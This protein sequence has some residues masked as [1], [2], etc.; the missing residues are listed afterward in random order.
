MTKWFAFIFVLG[1]CS[2][3][4]SQSVIWSDDFSSPSN[5]NMTNSSQ[6]ISTDWTITSNQLDIPDCAPTLLPFESASSANGFALINSYGQA[7][8]QDGDGGIVAQITNATPIDLSSYPNV[9]LKFQ[10]SYRWW[11]GT[12]GVRVS[13]DNGASWTEFNLTDSSYY[14][15]NRVSLNP[16]SERF[17]ISL[18]AGGQSQVLI[19]FYY[20]DN[21][22]REWFWA[23]DDVQIIEQPSDDIEIISDW[24]IGKNKNGVEYNRIPDTGFDTTY[25]LGVKIFNA[26]V[27]DQSN[28]KFTAEF[29]LYGLILSDSVP[30]LAAGDSV[31][32]EIPAILTISSSYSGTYSIS[33]E[34]DTI[35]G[36]N[37]S[38]NNVDKRFEF[39]DPMWAYCIL[40]RKEMYNDTSLLLTSVGTTSFEGGEG[41]LIFASL[42]QLSSWDVI[43][44]VQVLIGEGTALGSEVFVAIRDSADFVNNGLS[45]QIIDFNVGYVNAGDIADGE[46]EIGLF[47]L[48]VNVESSFYLTVES[49]TG[50]TIFIVDD[51]TY[52][53]PKGASLLYSMADNTFHQDGVS[54]GIRLLVNPEG[55]EEVS[56]PGVSIFPNPSNG[57]VTVTNDYFSDHSITI[58]NLLGDVV[59]KT[60]TNTSLEVDLSEVQAGVYLF[61]IENQ[62][63]NMVRRIIID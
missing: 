40:D 62:N 44:G 60:E 57:K 51:Q 56:M 48:L 26:G 36:A 29:P 46:M 4:I 63:D 7:G 21:N 58:L 17:N 24:S 23:L 13:G 47:P 45:S 54:F 10:H 49:Y 33:S 59:F 14:P 16:E 35:G 34:N 15:V 52:N 28:V 9:V 53:Q 3:G 31:D 25:Y 19:Q 43:D 38:N 50:E 41:G 20:T 5:W 8:N 22:Y 1:Y 11:H 42:F 30:F 2:I 18:I 12:R 27:N 32:I 39:V 37:S 55:L 6:P 61:Q